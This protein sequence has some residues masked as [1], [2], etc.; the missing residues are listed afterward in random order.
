MATDSP[1]LQSRSP[2]VIIFSSDSLTIT[3]D[4][5]FLKQPA[6]EWPTELLTRSVRR[7]EKDR[8]VLLSADLRDAADPVLIDA[9]LAHGLRRTGIAAGAGLER[10]L[11]E[12]YRYSQSAGW[13]PRGLMA[14]VDEESFVKEVPVSEIAEVNKPANPRRLVFAQDILVRAGGG[15]FSQALVACDSIRN[16]IAL[17]PNSSGIVGG[18][19][20]SC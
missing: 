11:D 18:C 7:A 9:A 13:A 6:R 20:V 2:V 17:Q 14:Q 4:Q 1:L 8:A 16:S 3:S 15:E 19:A 10:A 5:L 12:V